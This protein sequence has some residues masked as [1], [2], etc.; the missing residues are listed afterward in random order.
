MCDKEVGTGLPFATASDP[1]IPRKI[2][3]RVFDSA[4]SL[5]AIL[6]GIWG[7]FSAVAIATGIEARLIEAEA[8]L[9][10]G[11]AATWLDRL[12][13]LRADAK[14][15]PTPL[16]TTYRPVAGTTLAPLADP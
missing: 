10:T 9:K 13:Q 15:L 2:G 3:G 12:N 11:D 4:T 7:R 16:D 6:Q 5:T 14:L 8:A 1:R